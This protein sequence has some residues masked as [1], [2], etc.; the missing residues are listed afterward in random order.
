MYRIEHKIKLVQAA[1][2]GRNIF[3]NEETRPEAKTTYHCCR[4]DHTNVLYITPYG[5]GFPISD[6]Y[7]E[8][9]KGT[10]REALLEHKLLSPTSR[11]MQHLGPLTV[12]DLPTLYFGMDCAICHTPH[13][14]IFGYGE[15]QPGLEILAISG[16]WQ[17]AVQ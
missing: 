14:C 11:W 10:G 8:E 16:V 9:G 13:L 6:L 15:Q 2:T 7:E 1:A 4:C 5:S 17:Y 12:R 3:H